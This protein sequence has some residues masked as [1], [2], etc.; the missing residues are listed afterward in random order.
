L[1]TEAS[2]LWIDSRSGSGEIADLHQGIDE[3][4]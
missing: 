1:P 2:W 4:T 3:K